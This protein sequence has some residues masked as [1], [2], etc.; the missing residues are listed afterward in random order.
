MLLDNAEELDFKNQGGSRLDI[1]GCPA[2]AISDSW[3]A[4]Q[5]T[6]AADLHLLQAFGPALDHISQGKRRWLPTLDR[7]VKDGPIDEGTLIV[8]LHG[9]RDLR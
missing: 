8:D 5:A 1:R 7:T 3:R 2:V 4:Y 9:I 6:L